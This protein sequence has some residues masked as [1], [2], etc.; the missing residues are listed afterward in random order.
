MAMP[1]LT[2]GT[3]VFAADSGTA[4]TCNYLTLE[5]DEVGGKTAEQF[6]SGEV[7]CLRNG[8]TFEGE[9]AF[10]QTLKTGEDDTAFDAR[11][12]LNAGSATVGKLE[13]TELAVEKGMAFSGCIR[14]VKN[15]SDEQECS[16]LGFRYS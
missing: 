3:T 10:R 4:E 11:P 15:P 2:T 9:L 6:A 1:S 8:W 7:T 5:A 16:P 13:G 14:R 12:V